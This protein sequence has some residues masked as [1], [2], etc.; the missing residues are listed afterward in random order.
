[1]FVKLHELMFKVP[2]ENIALPLCFALF[3]EN[4]LYLI[5]KLFV[6]NIAPP[7]LALLLLNA[8]FEIFKFPVL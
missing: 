5:V 8:V 2:F 6:L 7:F 3:E 4:V 1:M